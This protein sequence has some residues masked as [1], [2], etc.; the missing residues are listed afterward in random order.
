MLQLVMKKLFALTITIIILTIGVVS[1]NSISATTLDTLGNS[2]RNDMPLKL[3][4]NLELRLI[5][6]YRES[7]G[8]SRLKYSDNLTNSA[9]H[10][11][12]YLAENNLFQHNYSDEAWYMHFDGRKWGTVGEILGRAN[13]ENFYGTVLLDAWLNSPR[14]KAEIEKPIYTHFGMAKVDNLTCVHFG[15][16]RD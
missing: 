10:K 7:I 3:P 5:N 11:C 12:S 9:Y 13:S 16:P 15:S 6:D 14:H 2:V 4:E 1:A 8:L